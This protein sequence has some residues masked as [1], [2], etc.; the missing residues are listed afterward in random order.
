[1]R[2]IVTG[3]AGFLGSHLCDAL[4]EVTAS[5]SVVQFE[6]LPQDDPKRHCPEISVESQRLIFE[7][8]CRC[9]SHTSWQRYRSRITRD[10]ERPRR[11]QTQ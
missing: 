11:P 5:K 2:V 9:R 7:L 6:P 4:L 8:G 10:T 3:G 1:M